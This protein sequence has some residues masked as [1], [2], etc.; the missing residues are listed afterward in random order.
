MEFLNQFNLNKRYV[1]DKD[2][3]TE[4]MASIDGYISDDESEDYWTNCCNNKEIKINTEEDGEIVSGSVIY[5]ILP[6][7]C[8]EIPSIRLLTEEDML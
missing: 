8:R 6:C 1:F 4:Y 3:Y 5:A 2:I 7:W